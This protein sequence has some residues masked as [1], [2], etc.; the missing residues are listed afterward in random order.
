MSDDAKLTVADYPLAE[1]RP[2]LVRTRS[3]R[4][5]DTVTL[6]SVLDGGITMDD[7]RITPEALR[8]QAEVADAAGRP[9]LAQNFMRA[10]ELVN[11]PEDEILRIYEMLRPGRAKSRAELVT[12]AQGLRDRHAAHGMAGFIEEA[13]EIYERR[14]LFRFRF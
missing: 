5:L 12:L 10:A 1:M 9:T 6:E 4:A 7:L 11:V 13:A 14:G 3:G 8:Q 2:D